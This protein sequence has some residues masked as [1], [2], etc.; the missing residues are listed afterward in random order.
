MA[1][2]A[3]ELPDARVVVSV[4]SHRHG[5]AVLRLLEDLAQHARASV[6]SV[7]LTL[8]VPEPDLEEAAL[9]WARATGVA[10]HVRR[11]AQ[12]RGF[13]AN[14]NAAFA[15]CGNAPY[16]AVLNPDV[17]FD[18]DPF[19]A[20]C[21]ALVAAPGA[22]C[23]YP[24]QVDPQGRACYP[25]RVVPTPLNL[26]RRY[27]GLAEPVG[28]PHW[29]NAAFLVFDAR[30]YAALGGFDPAYWLYCEDVDLCLR[31]QNAGLRLVRGDARVHH[32]GRRAS[33][34]GL[35]H[36][37]WHVRSLWRLWHSPALRAFERAQRQR[38]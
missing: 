21:A 29:V 12:R 15:L 11:N 8:N 10:L 19:P 20:L 9:A 38:D 7:V 37:Y 6:A 5:D 4:V 22:A 25:P 31:L 18:R 27:L 30:A 2:E 34:V 3:H 24:Q 36:L 16:F 33:H 26:L 13:G 17:R 28:G 32:L 35:L 1:F 14:H 23:A